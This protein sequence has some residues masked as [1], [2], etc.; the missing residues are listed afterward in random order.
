M[1]LLDGLHEDLN[2]V[3]E[4]PYLEHPNSEGRPDAE[5]AE[6]WWSNHLRREDSVVV[7]L[8]AGQFKSSVV[9]RHCSYKSARFEPFMFL[10]VLYSWEK[11]SLW[12]CRGLR[13]G[14]DIPKRLGG[15]LDL[16]E[17]QRARV[18]IL[19]VDAVKYDFLTLGRNI[20]NR[21]NTR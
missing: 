14:E 21:E 3:A 15:C 12:C 11:A 10:Q 19:D 5:L 2:R 8:F 16:E 4:T 1:F 13:G 17:N 20:S 18:V 7:E 6:I 9:C